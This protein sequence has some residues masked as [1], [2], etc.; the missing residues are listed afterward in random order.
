MS[1]SNTTFTNLSRLEIHRLTKEA[2]KG[3]IEALKM[4]LNFLTRFEI[5]SFKVI[6]YLIVYQ[7]VM[8]L[9]LEL[10][11]DCEKCGGTCCKSGPEI[12]LYSFDL[13]ELKNVDSLSIS[14]AI[15]CSS[16]YCYL[17]RPCVFQVEWRCLIHRYKPYACL[18]Y[19]F[20]SEE[21]QYSVISNPRNIPPLPIIPDTCIAAKKVWI[22]IYSKIEE[23]KE[24]HRRAPEPLEVLRLMQTTT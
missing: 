19:P 22:K 9:D 23:F 8:N 15:K 17:L 20:T 24:K 21:V 16:G 6:A 18:S 1:G 11:N 5:R 12:P 7:T 14:K 4:V 3:S 2:L 13:E 10:G